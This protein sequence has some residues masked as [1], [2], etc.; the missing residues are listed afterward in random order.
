MHKYR[1]VA[2][3]AAWYDDPEAEDVQPY[4]PFKKIRVRS[5][6]A[7][8]DAETSP[9][10]GLVRVRSEG[11]LKDKAAEKSSAVDI[12]R[13]TTTPLAQPPQNKK[14]DEKVDEPDLEHGLVLLLDKTPLREERAKVQADLSR[15]QKHSFAHKIRRFLW[16]KDTDILNEG[17]SSTGLIISG[18][19]F[20]AKPHPV[21]SRRRAFVTSLRLID[22]KYGLITLDIH[23][24]LLQCLNDINRNP[25]YSIEYRRSS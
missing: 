24:S 21:S 5:A 22:G 1:S 12:I 3:R 23:T 13:T 18:T 2:R 17:L 7:H 14:I 11:Y 4:N 6:P 20:L 16:R 9:P 25:L 10:E 19:V 8:S 15:L